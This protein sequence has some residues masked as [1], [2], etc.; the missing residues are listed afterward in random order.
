MSDVLDRG[1]RD[2]LVTL[3]RR[4]VALGLD[5]TRSLLAALGNPQAKMPVVH[6]AGTNGKGSVA[7]MIESILRAAGWKTGLYTSPH[8][9][10]LGERVQVDR[11]P[12]TNAAL[13]AYVRELRGIVDQLVR[14]DG[15]SARPTYFEFMTAVA[16]MHF[17]RLKCDIAV[18]EA[19]MGGRLDA[20]NVVDPAVSVVTS[21]GL[22]H[23]EFLGHTLEEIAAEKAG[24]VKPQRPLVIG[25][26]P[27]SA[28]RVVRAAAT[29]QS[30][31]VTAIAEVF[32]EQIDR[33]PRTNLGGEYQRLNAATAK[34][35]I[36]QLGPAWHIDD[37][38][39]DRALMNVSWPARWQRFDLHGRAVIV[40]ASHNAEGAAALDEN[41]SRLREVLGQRPIVVVGALGETRARALLEV[42][43]R[44]AA[45]VR[46]VVPQQNRACRYEQLEALIPKTTVLPV[47]RCTVDE[48]FPHAGVCLPNE[49]I[50]RSVVV[51]GS[52]YLAGEVLARIDP[53]LGPVEHELQ[54]F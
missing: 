53:T 46:L 23:T 39:I 41:L 27:F 37:E 3:K 31:P 5:R 13:A 25:R 19:G 15:E 36:Q 52:I 48:I 40:D 34:C 2:Y 51:T 10:R 26:L 45:D 14:R 28:E 7:A 20:T 50:D 47:S 18:V 30:S 21:I 4:G 35:A 6:I 17:V 32:G 44:H 8:L 9:V 29:G 33:Y 38:T 42:I 11:E 49:P 24:I 16:W 54:D 43:V 22:D 1:T 12:L